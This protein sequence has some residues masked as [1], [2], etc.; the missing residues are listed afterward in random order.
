MRI[1]RRIATATLA[2]L[3]GSAGLTAVAA[4]PAAAAGPY[5][6][7]ILSSVNSARAAHGLRPY[8]L[9]SDLSS[10]AYSWSQHMAATG[11]LSHNPRLT[12]QVTNWRWV[13]ENVGYAPDWKT[14]MAAFMASPAHRANILDSDFTEIGIGVVVKGSTIWV[15]QDFRQPMHSSSTTTTRT[16]TTT[17]RTRTTTTSRPVTSRPVVSR[18]VVHAAPP[19]PPSPEQLLVARIHASAARM[20][21]R[22][23]D[24]IAAALGFSAAMTSVAR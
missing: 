17:T 11:T 4:S 16:R 15:T 12:T 3:V 22:G 23:A 7:N 2:V 24:P 18:P 8:A 20:P 9:R 1:W 21:A 14:V 6:S 19:A 5:T 13:G 10:V